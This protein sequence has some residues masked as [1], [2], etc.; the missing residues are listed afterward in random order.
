MT[1]LIDFYELTMA[2]TDWKNGKDQEKCY[3]DIFFRKNLDGGGFNV[4]CGLDDIIDYIEKMSFAEDDIAYL[5][6]LKVFDEAFLAYLRDFRFTG[7]LYAIPDGTPIFPQEPVITVYGHTIETQLLETDLLNR[8]NHGSLIATKT[9]RIVNETKG[10]PVMEFGARRAQGVDAAVNGAKFAYI[11]GAA[12]TSCYETGKRY[13][14]PILG[15]MAHSHVMK[16]ATE[17]E[18][19]LAYA[20][21]F[22]DNSI[23]L[24]DT[25]NTLKSGV[26]NAIK[27]AQDFLIPNGYR[28]K[29]IRLDSGDLAY[30][31]KQARIMLD[32]AGLTD[33]KISV[34]NALDEQ[35]I[36]DILEEGAQIDSFGVGENLITS[37][38][39]PV[40]DG[41]YKLA[42]MEIDGKIVPKI[43]V[44]ETI[45]KV[46]NPGYKKVYRFY[47]QK[48]GYALGDLIALADEQLPT[49]E[50]ILFDEY[51]T[52]KQTKITD[53]TIRPLQEKIYENGKLIYQLPSLP[54]RKAYCEQ[55]INTLYP[56]VQRINHPHHYY[57]DLSRALYD[58]KRQLIFQ[59]TG[60]K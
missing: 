38:N 20:Q 28:L 16:Y 21:V 15:T 22:P 45:A 39:D 29:G 57:V 13:H 56:E 35:S 36:K 31:S 23:F 1:K 8:F 26:P 3:F 44:S 32:E 7:D 47:D 10:R 59:S 33:C 19:F 30:L 14:I 18:A 40:F 60:K 2:Y 48:T 46:T 52:W 12:G 5:R 43:K 6:S 41:V 4:A 53:Y 58:L 49:H 24:V 25:N 27:V 51:E 37:K 42:A 55:Q 54:E 50:Y 9:R 34:S 11:A 17:Y